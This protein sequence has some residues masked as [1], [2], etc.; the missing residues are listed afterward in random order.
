LFLSKK[1]NK[2]L[3]AQPAAAQSGADVATQLPS[4]PSLSGSRSLSLSQ[5]QTN[6][7]RYSMLGRVQVCHGITT[8]TWRTTN[9]NNNN[10]QPVFDCSLKKKMQSGFVRALCKLT[11]KYAV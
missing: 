7:H 11:F 2:T 1:P 3:T 6:T 5:C 4:V 8:T 10:V 9:N